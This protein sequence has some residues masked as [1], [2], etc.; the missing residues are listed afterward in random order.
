M[1]Q[2]MKKINRSIK[3]FP[4]F[5]CIAEDLILF[6]PIDMLFLSIAKGLNASQI[7]S[8]T[9]ISLLVCIVTQKMILKGIK[10][11]GNIKSVRL[12]T[13]LIFISSILL[14]FG[15]SFPLILLYRS[16]F[17]IGMLL[18]HM[19]Y[20]I[21]NNNLKSVNNLEE[22]SKIRNK[23]NIMYAVI[24][25]ITALL[26]GYLFNLNNYLPMY[27]QIILYFVIFVMSF[28]FYENNKEALNE[29]ISIN[30][31]ETE[32]IE[33]DNIKTT[34]NKQISSITTLLLLS[35]VFTSGIIKM[36]Q[37]NSKLFMQYDF[38]EFLTLENVIYYITVIV[39]ISRIARII[40]NVIFDKIYPKLKDKTNI[41]LSLLLAI[42]FLFIIIGHYLQ[43]E[44]IYKV[45]FMAIGF[46]LILAIR[47]PLFVYLDDIALKVVKIEE[48]EEIITKLGV[49][50][51]IG[52]LLMSTI[53]TFVL[54]KYDLIVVIFSL[55]VLA[56]IGIIL[57]K[58]LYYKLKLIYKN[59]L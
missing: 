17:E 1:E 53:F 12:G 23:A 30:S 58:V 51:N 39:F 15:S 8:I 41:I 5:S 31:E 21:L 34:N 49:A 57:N 19:I 18:M 28:G 4:I 55:L 50:R 54:V 38:L 43:V 24:T 3:L 45:I 56:I 25:M 36:G 52:N 40:G 35:S 2:T 27:L 37:S 32:K 29:R 59:E 11:L 26:S 13:F 10:K 42:S 14:T 46:C 6:I 20:V 22:Y 44:F 48:K 33:K 47:A 7:A 9:M 16:I